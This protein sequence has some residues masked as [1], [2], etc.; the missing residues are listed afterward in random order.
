MLS[1]R[2]YMR[3]SDPEQKSSVLTWL[4][5]ALISAFVV[6]LISRTWFTDSTEIIPNIA[7]T[8]KGLQS[9][10]VWTLFTYGFLHWEYPN[11]LYI[12]GVIAGV[13]IF[14]RELLPSLG[15]RRFAG[16]YAG[17]LILGGLT[18]AAA[19]WSNPDA[20]ARL[21]GGMPGVFGLLT[22]FACL[23]PNQDFSFTFFF[24]PV[25]IKPK[26]LAVGLALVEF[27][28]FIYWELFRKSAPFSYAASAH[29]GGMAAGLIYYR[30]IHT[31]RWRTVPAEA[32][33]ELAR[34]PKT[35]PA[36]SAALE[37]VRINPATRDELRAE[38]D[39][40]LDKINSA[41]FN[42]LTP[43]EKRVLDDARDQLTRR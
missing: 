31:A 13:V 24:F 28:A 41:G 33:L 15:P 43:A 6:E 1:D 8:I 27:A 2:F 30:F 37:P 18:W 9:G 12:A 16:L 17:A 39:R 19:N 14:G 7:V 29:L 32:D 23:Y 11:L 22:V 20:H 10:R 38:V 5:A 40:I 42:A 4:V 3:D 21:F 25:T 26:H 34:W 36:K 35:K